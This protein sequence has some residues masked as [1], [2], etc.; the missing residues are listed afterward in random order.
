[1]DSSI[2][3]RSDTHPNKILVMD[4]HSQL[5]YLIGKIKK[6]LNNNNFNLKEERFNPLEVRYKRKIVGKLLYR[7]GLFQFL[8]D[9]I[10][11]NTDLLMFM[12]ELGFQSLKAKIQTRS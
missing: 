7:K 10:E 11:T 8:L 3:Q 12:D 5:Q 9:K 2:P 6:A 4:I 1:M